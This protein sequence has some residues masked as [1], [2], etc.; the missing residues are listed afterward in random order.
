MDRLWRV[1]FLDEDLVNEQVNKQVTTLNA[2]IKFGTWV[3][4]RPE[5]EP[6]IKQWQL[7][8]WEEWGLIEGK[9]LFS[10]IK[11]GTSK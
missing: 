5:A 10:E 8:N 6:D 7:I 4:K 1:V 9:H 3:R 11:A 2:S